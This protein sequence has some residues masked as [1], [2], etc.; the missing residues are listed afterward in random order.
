MM[1][2]PKFGSELTD[3]VINLDHLR[4]KRISGTTHPR[5]FFQLKEIFHIMESVG[6]ARIEGNNTTVAEY[7]ETSDET[8]GE[9][10][11]IREI[12]NIEKAYD[13]I[14]K[15]VEQYPINRMFIS[16]LHRIIVD[17]LDRTK[18]GDDTPGQYRKG[19]VRITKSAHVPPP[20]TMVPD[21][22]EELINFINREDPPK[23]DLLKTAIAHH[24]FAWIHPFK[25]GNGRT[26]RMLTYAMLIKQGFNIGSARIVNP[27]AVFCSSRDNYY[28][29]LAKADTGTEE[30]LTEWCEYVLRG[31]ETEIDKIDRLTDHDYLVS[32]IL[33][34][35]LDYVLDRGMINEI[36]HKILAVAI[37][38]IIIQAS[39]IKPIV[40]VKHSSQ[41]SRLIAKLKEDHLLVSE[42][43][44]GRKYLIDLLG[45][46]M[47]RG[48]IYAL[49]EKGFLPENE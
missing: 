23:Y 1:I 7:I 40:G 28:G 35:A 8:E 38:E 36:E 49:G 12:R 24:R 6:S 37:K 5:I 41:V 17:G 14:E 47:M 19:E 29:Y 45:K 26:V 30:G 46:K 27:T 21:L 43:E 9:T 33:I 31:L 4:R 15:N 20:Y 2:E 11:A 25:N 34:P 48:I 39:D 44:G 16:E 3:L 42:Q 18:E 22:M 10:D 32:E 13:F